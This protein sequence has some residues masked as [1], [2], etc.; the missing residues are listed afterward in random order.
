MLYMDTLFFIKPFLTIILYYLKLR[1]LKTN[2]LLE[3][4]YLQLI[5]YQKYILIFV[6]V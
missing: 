6:S 5:K 1:L 2:Y 4:N 3:E